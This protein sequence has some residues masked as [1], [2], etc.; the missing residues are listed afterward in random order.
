M[1][2]H[3]C[4]RRQWVVVSLWVEPEDCWGRVASV[5]GR[6][7]LIYRLNSMLSIQFTKCFSDLSYYNRH[8]RTHTGKKPFKCKY[9]GKWLSQSSNC[10]VHEQ[11]HTGEKRHKCKLCR[12][13]FY[14]LADLEEHKQTHQLTTFSC[15]ICQEE[16]SSQ[17]LL[18]EHYDNHMVLSIFY[19]LWKVNFSRRGF[20]KHGRHGLGN[21]SRKLWCLAWTNGNMI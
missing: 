21:M 6:C 7:W 11:R 8:E 17:H 13:P 1:C 4:L 10:N 19:E 16:L 14:K 20:I 15:W 5:S 2:F 12:K 18:M 3:G 9:C